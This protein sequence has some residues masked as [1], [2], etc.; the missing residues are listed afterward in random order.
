[1]IARTN[2]PV[3]LSAGATG[4]RAPRKVQDPLLH[5]HRLREP[6]QTLPGAQPVQAGHSRGEGGRRKCKYNYL[7]LNQPSP[8]CHH[9][10]WEMP[11]TLLPSINP[12]LTSTHPTLSSIPNQLRIIHFDVF[13]YVLCSLEPLPADYQKHLRVIRTNVSEYRNV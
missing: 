3:R 12:H 2:G 6:A 11:P 7:L 13:L 4:A 9:H 1:M 10:P 5:V 8:H